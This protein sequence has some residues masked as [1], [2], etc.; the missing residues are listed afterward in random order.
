[1]REDL[2]PVQRLGRRGLPGDAGVPGA[3]VGLLLGSLP[4]R[5]GA[6]RGAVVGLLLGLLPR[7][8][9][10]GHPRAPPGVLGPA[11]RLPHLLLASFNW[12]VGKPFPDWR[13]DFK[14]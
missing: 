2:F 11:P 4:R 13:F 3:V 5:H 14:K 7:R 12:L 10:A 9:G 1:M 8:E 6:Y